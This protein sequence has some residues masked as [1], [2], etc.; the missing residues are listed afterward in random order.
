MKIEKLSVG[1]SL[2]LFVGGAGVI[3][4]EAASKKPVIDPK[5]DTVL[6]QLSDHNKQVKARRPYSVGGGDPGGRK[7]PV[8]WCFPA[9]N[10]TGNW[11]PPPVTTPHRG[12]W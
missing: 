6:H 5:A 3:H 12:K 7:S 4:S 2:L 8:P 10:L 11:G 1:M 9:T